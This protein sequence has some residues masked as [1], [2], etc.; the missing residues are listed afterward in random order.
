M[1]SRN[2]LLI[3]VFSLVFASCSDDDDADMDDDMVV[4]TCDDNIQNGDE[5]GVDCGGSACAPCTT[6][7]E[8]PATYVF[9]RD[10]SS[11]VSFSGQ[12]TRLLMAS[13]ILSK[14]RDNNSTKA[15]I[16]AAF[17]H[18][19]D[20]ENFSDA[21]LN[22][23][24]KQVRNKTAGS[25]FF[26]QVAP[27]VAL[28]NV[29][30]DFDGYITEQ[31]EDVFPFWN[32]VA[33]EGSA[34]QLPDGSSTRYVN[35]RGLELDQAFIKGLTGAFVVDQIVNNY[36]NPNQLAQFEDDNDNEVIVEGESYTDMEH[37]WDEAYGYFFGVVENSE[38]PI[39]DIDAVDDNPDE[40]LA[41]YLD[42]VE[43][44]FPGIAQDIFDA[45]RAGRTAIINKDYT[46]RDAQADILR[47]KIAIL[48]A[49]RAVHYLKAGKV[50]LGGPQP[51]TTF[52][53]LS[54]A[55]GFIYSLQFLRR[56]G[57]A[58]EFYF[59][60]DEALGFLDIIYNTP[61]NG[62]WNVTEENLD[63]VA[64]AI[65]DKFSFTVEEVD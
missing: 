60:R 64:E 12:T 2:L 16:D 21:D 8:I 38:N 27:S 7:V 23:S 25:Y 1:F 44:N 13:E 20:T 29:K 15:E 26:S 36:T 11:T 50:G 3:V 51:G 47:E 4:A 17:D 54:E 46:E 65:A 40:F 56:P 43:A 35:G 41:K 10:G 52:H 55:Y 33:T 48:V 31:V 24:D 61:T 34:G 63:T 58:T 14:L 5:E 53:D 28:I 57:T 62:F 19:Q 49:V 18:E 42:N 45:Y 22:A 30:A 59:S 37:D 6:A 32:Q 9:E 39:A